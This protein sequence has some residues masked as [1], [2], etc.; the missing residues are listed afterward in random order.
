MI[1]TGRVTIHKINKN[2]EV[3]VFRYDSSSGQAAFQRIENEAASHS[4]EKGSFKT[5]DNKAIVDWASLIDGY[6]YGT[7]FG[8]PGEELFVIE[9][10][11]FKN[12]GNPDYETFKS[13]C[14][15]VSFVPSG[16]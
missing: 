9:T 13:L 5:S 6:T 10:S 4:L 1:Q 7:M 12:R 8:P 2:G 11:K 16:R 14:D 3:Q 15:K